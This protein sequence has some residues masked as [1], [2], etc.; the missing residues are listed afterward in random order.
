MRLNLPEELIE[1]IALYL[2]AAGLG[3]LRLASRL[4]NNEVFRSWA[5]CLHTIRTDLGSH[6]LQRLLAIGQTKTIRE[7]IHILFVHASKNS[8]YGGGLEWSRDNTG[9]LLTSQSNTQ[10]KLLQTCLCNE[11]INCRSFYIHGFTDQIIKSVLP[12]TSEVVTLFL[13][14]V[15]E[16]GLKLQSFT[17][18]LKGEHPSSAAR[19][20]GWLDSRRLQDYSSSMCNQPQFRQGW[21]HLQEL[22]L[23]QDIRPGTVEW[24]R[25]LIQKAPQLRNLSL[26]FDSSDESVCEKVLDV[27]VPP[28][29]DVYLDFVYITAP[30]LLKFLRRSQPTM[31]KLKLLSIHLLEVGSI[32]DDG[33][34]RHNDWEYIFWNLRTKFPNLSNISFFLLNGGP[35]LEVP[36]SKVRFQP[37][38]ENERQLSDELPDEKFDLTSRKLR[39]K[40]PD[41]Q[42]EEIASHVL[43]LAYEGR[44][45]ARALERIEKAVEYC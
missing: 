39:R 1:H 18:D 14:I 37:L 7:H 31:Q 8:E 6:S 44:H 29:K 33:G 21:S 9:S 25:D 22:H 35:S 45:M 10:F 17:V 4:L 24:T 12:T 36:T 19:G 13:N 16:T 42:R 32:N 30:K 23:Y 34:C 11:M 41:G 40:L 27:E 20:S 28:L 15:A 3:A 38:L 2:D 43:G 26:T 5:K